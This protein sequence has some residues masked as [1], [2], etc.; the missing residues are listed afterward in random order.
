MDNAPFPKSQ[1]TSGSSGASSGMA[2]SGTYTPGQSGA[3]SST[4][5]ADSGM[6]SAAQSAENTAHQTVDRVSAT[7]H[8]T[9]DRL[10]N[11]AT[12]LADRLDERTRRLTDAPLRAWDYSRSS[13]QEH[14]MQAVA[15]ALLVGYVMGRLSGSRRGYDFD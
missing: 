13:V 5:S 4:S 3:A 7:A 11:S 9:V 8:E 14:P 1:S 15:A 10:A 6:H 2:G 12:R